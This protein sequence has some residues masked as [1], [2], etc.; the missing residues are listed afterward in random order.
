MNKKIF[1]WVV[2]LIVSVI[3]AFFENRESFLGRA[4]YPCVEKYPLETSFPCYGSFSIVVILIAVFF[5]IISIIKIL[6]FIFK[7]F[8]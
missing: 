5:A 2:V 4:L 6:T 8:R 1:I 3:V 7:K